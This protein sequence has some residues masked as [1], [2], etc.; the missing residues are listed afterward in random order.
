MLRVIKLNR[1]K[2]VLTVF[3][4]VLI[5]AAMITAAIKIAN[6]S[7]GNP[8]VEKDR[9]SVII[10]PGHGGV[11]GGAVGVNGVVEKNINLS[12]S[13]KLRE[14]FRAA[15]YEVVMTR[16]DDRSIHSP[17][18]KT[19]REQKTSDLYNRLDFMKKNPKAIFIS[20]HQNKFEQSRYSGTQVFYSANMLQS[21]ILAQTIQQE[22][23]KA[24]QPENTRQI[25]Q[26]DKNLFII[27]NA[28]IPAVMVECGFLS[29]PGEALKL[30][31]TDYQN[32]L[33]F[34]VFY[35]VLKT[36]GETSNAAGR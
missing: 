23:R 5:C 13:L 33:A 19:V 31:D 29:N 15:G 12:I 9:R 14:F 1:S 10:D 6:V 35:A 28:P 11:D 34:T 27:Y 25:K 7:S 18:A 16:E 2:A 32:K 8:N 20:I 22:I 3:F 26:A 30:Q 17:D 4:C 36:Y 21:R 24:L